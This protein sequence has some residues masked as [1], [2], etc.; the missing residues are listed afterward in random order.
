M[1]L[2]SMHRWLFTHVLLLAVCCSSIHA[3]FMTKAD[4]SVYL[5][6][7]LHIKIKKS[8]EYS[9]VVDK[10]IYF[11]NEQAID[12]YIK[13]GITYNPNSQ[14][15][16]ILDAYT[17]YQHQH[18]AVDTS[19]I[20]DKAIATDNS[21]FDNRHIM[22]IPFKHLKPGSKLHIKYLKENF[23]VADPGR[24]SMLI[25][26]SSGYWQ[27]FSVKV[28]AP[29]KLNWQLQNVCKNFTVSE[30]VKRR[31]F[32]FSLIS[33][34]PFS[35]GLID[36][37][38]SWL[39]NPKFQPMLMLSN[40][41][42]WA[43]VAQHHFL[44]KYE[45]VLNESLPKKYAQACQNLKKLPSLTRFNRVISYVQNQMHYLGDWRTI[46]GKFIPRPLSQ[47]VRSGYGDCKDY[48]ALTVAMLRYLGYQAHVALVVRAY[49]YIEP[50]IQVPGFFF[51]HAVVYVVLKNGQHFWLDPTNRVAFAGDVFDDIANRHALVLNHAKQNYHTIASDRVAFAETAIKQKISFK[52]DS[53]TKNIHVLVSGHDAIPLTALAR[54]YPNARI[55]DFIYAAFTSHNIPHEDRLGVIKP[56]LTSRVVQPIKLSVQYVERQYPF[57]VTNVGLAAPLPAIFNLTLPSVNSQGDVPLKPGRVKHYYVLNKPINAAENLN[58]TINSPWMNLQRKVTSRNNQT[59]IHDTLKV[60]R[61]FI[62]AD[63]RHDA[64]YRRFLAEM[65]KYNKLN[66]IV[67]AN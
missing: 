49:P 59:F 16:Q 52:S 66:A 10:T 42:S 7:S 60:K 24:F 56:A 51:N 64:V 28:T 45:A 31:Q 46:K 50:K 39:L 48:A 37:L 13:Y 67:F 38:P 14:R 36:E 4:A 27:N 18:H 65:H 3:R 57:L 53:V 62:H 1:L 25:A 8:G 55:N 40:Y 19:L 20:K 6:Q 44:A 23:I 26:P 58:F 15:L 43:D 2:Q 21:G 9:T 29:F 5:K 33:K 17:E 32:N 34:A 54:Y 47:V 61:Y 12:R 63:E 35:V 30:N 41:S 22:T 11:V